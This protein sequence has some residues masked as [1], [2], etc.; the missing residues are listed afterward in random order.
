MSFIRN[1]NVWKINK[2]LAGISGGIKPEDVQDMIDTSLA[3]YPDNTEFET[4]LGGKQDTLT[5]GDG[6]EIND[7]VI[8]LKGYTEITE[9]KKDYVLNNAKTKNL[10]IKYGSRYFKSDKINTDASVTGVTFHLINNMSMSNKNPEIGAIGIKTNITVYYL[11][12]G[13]GNFGQINVNFKFYDLDGMTI[14]SDTNVTNYISNGTIIKPFMAQMRVSYNGN[15]SLPPFIFTPNTENTITIPIAM[16]SSYHKTSDFVTFNK[17]LSTIL[18][19]V[20]NSDYNNWQLIMGDTYYNGLE[21]Y[22]DDNISESNIVLYA[23]N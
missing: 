5:A 2:I 23:E 14:I 12:Q 18:S 6:I 17:G 16:Y 11:T 20:G 9:N 1:N 3:N 8:S 21:I 7:N 19:Y 10:I 15:K 4:A 13:G 22:C